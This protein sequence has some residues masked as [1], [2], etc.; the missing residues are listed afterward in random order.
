MSLSVDGTGKFVYVAMAG[1][2][3]SPGYRI[4]AATG[5][6]KLLPGISFPQRQAE[7]AGSPMVDP[8]RNVLHITYMDCN[9]KGYKIDGATGALS[10]LYSRA[11]PGLE[12][13]FM[14]ITPPPAK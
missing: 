12:G 4:D 13:C 14:A 8:S 7:D 10:P 3:G 9:V 5:A 2:H 6:L 11:F 1:S